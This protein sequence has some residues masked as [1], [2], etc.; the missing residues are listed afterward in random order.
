LKLE[1]Y[2]IK[3]INMRELAKAVRQVVVGDSGEAMTEQPSLAGDE[4]SSWSSI[5]RSKSCSPTIRSTTGRLSGLF[6]EDAL[7]SLRSRN[8]RQRSTASSPPATTTSC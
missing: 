3:P 1:T 5:D 4:H 6:E 7:S 8:G 2:L